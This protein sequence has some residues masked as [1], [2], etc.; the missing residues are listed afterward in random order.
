M[1]FRRNPANII[2]GVRFA[3]GLALFFCAPFTGGFY[4]LYLLGGLSDAV[5]GTVAR[6]LGAETPFG[7]RLDTAAD[8]VFVIAVLIKLSAE[9]RFPPWL[10][11]WI[12]VIAIIKCLSAV[13]GF[14]S[15][16]RFLTAHT[17]MNK[18]CGALLFAVPL[19][20]GR[21]P[22]TAFTALIAVSCAAATAAA[23]Q[24]SIIV[25]S[26]KEVR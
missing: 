10:T 20:V 25:R 12:I 11:V 15:C 26:G 19:C 17:V 6:R 14:I 18:L 1:Y 5:D 16:G 7:A 3:C 9:L 21:L 23:V 4:T 13:I 22:Q 2:S 24:E 8:A